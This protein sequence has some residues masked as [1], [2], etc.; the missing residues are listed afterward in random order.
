MIFDNLTAYLVLIIFQTTLFYHIQKCIWKIFLSHVIKSKIKYFMLNQCSTILFFISLNSD[1]RR[2]ENKYDTMRSRRIHLRMW[3]RNIEKF[4][5]ADTHTHTHVVALDVSEN[6]SNP[7]MCEKF[8]L[9]LSGHSEECE[10]VPLW[11]L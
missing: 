9:P 6:E 4:I 11:I 5:W 3:R 10:K 1:L 2:D 8:T 7:I